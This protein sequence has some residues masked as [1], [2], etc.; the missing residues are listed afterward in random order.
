MLTA[1]AERIEEDERAVPVATLHADG[2]WTWKGTPPHESNYAG[3]RM[4]VFTHPPA[5]PV[6]ENERTVLDEVKADLMACDW[7]E[8]ALFGVRDEPGE[9]D[10]CYLILP[11]NELIPFVHHA[12][13]G[14]DQARARFIADCCN[15]VL[16]PIKQPFTHPSA[17]AAQVPDALPNEWQEWPGPTDN[18]DWRDY[19]YMLGWNACRNV[20]LAT[21]APEGDA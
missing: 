12:I 19:G 15:Q 4:D 16:S 7:Q 14:V 10:P 18:D 1:F 21:C 8:G 5:Q 6:Q 9:H 20:M 2:F 3:W 11:S 13:N 17:Q